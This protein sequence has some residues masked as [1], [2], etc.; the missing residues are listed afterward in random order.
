MMKRFLYVVEGKA[1]CDKVKRAGCQYV[2]K[3]NGF[4]MVSRETVFI[5]QVLSNREVVL[6]FDPD[7]SGKKITDY[8][9]NHIDNSKRNN[10]HVAHILKSLAVGKGKVGVAE[11]KVSDIKECLKEYLKLEEKAIEE[12]LDFNDL[13]SLNLTGNNSHDKRKKL[14][15]KFKFHSTSLKDLLLRLNC[16]GLNKKEVEDVIY[17]D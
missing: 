13:I 5:N 11:A 16:L 4:G 17:E 8:I 9:I 14:E 15:E 12:E 7:G 6:F 10:L 1:D 2:I 3:T